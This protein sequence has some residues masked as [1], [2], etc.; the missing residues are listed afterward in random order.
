MF[1]KKSLAAAALLAAVGA[2]AQSTVTVYGNVEAAFGAFEDDYTHRVNK[3]ESNVLTGS[4]LGFKGQEDLGGG[5]KAFFKLESTIGVD[6]GAVAGNFWGRTSEIGLTN[7]YGTLT[8]GNSLSLSAL[9][10]QAQSPF[11]IFGR[12]NGLQNVAADTGF[13]AVQ[14]NTLT[15]SSA[16]YSGFSAAAQY[17]ASEVHGADSKY[18]AALNYAVGPVAA[19]FTYTNDDNAD[20]T[21]WQLGG[22]YDFGSFKA[23]AQIGQV[24]VTGPNDTDY[25]QL[26]VSAPVTAAG[27]VLASW[28]HA[29]T[30]NDGKADQL[31]VAYDHALSKRTGVF[32]GVMY[33][34][35]KPES[36]DSHSGLSLAVGLHHAF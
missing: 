29:K 9:A 6:T 36:G 23:F 7:A 17:G 32:G 10:N 30:D 18:A 24:E 33:E 15:L 27:T 22:S 11:S 12:L 25:F 35:F 3:V 20:R 14:A 13:G 2:H 4:F 21:L 19:G 8:A 1:A 16:N 34:Q 31:S 5:L 28:T 26:G